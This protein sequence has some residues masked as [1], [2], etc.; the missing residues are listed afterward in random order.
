MIVR[1]YSMLGEEGII[2]C[3]VLLSSHILKTTASASI[4]LSW[5]RTPYAL[6]STLQISRG[7]IAFTIVVHPVAF[8]QPWFLDQA[9]R[10]Q[11]FLG[12]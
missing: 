7:Y 8:V 10:C 9:V 11:L 6:A 1:D 5:Y 3:H 4:S 12:S 2:I